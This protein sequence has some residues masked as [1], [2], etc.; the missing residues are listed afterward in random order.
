MV[1]TELDSTAQLGTVYGHARSKQ[2]EDNLVLCHGH[3]LLI[4]R[5]DQKI[6]EER[7]LRKLILKLKGN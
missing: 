4:G 7:W 2:C 5:C 3:G 6:K 1:Q